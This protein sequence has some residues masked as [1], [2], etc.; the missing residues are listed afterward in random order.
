[1]SEI[2]PYTYKFVFDNDFVIGGFDIEQLWNDIYDVFTD[3]HEMYIERNDKREMTQKEIRK[4]RGGFFEDMEEDTLLIDSQYKNK[5]VYFWNGGMFWSH[6][7]QEHIQDVMGLY[8]Q[9]DYKVTPNN[10]ESIFCDF[11]VE[12]GKDKKSILCR[13]W[14][15]EEV[16]EREEWEKPQIPEILKFLN[17]STPGYEKLM[18]NFEPI[19]EHIKRWIDNKAKFAPTDEILNQR[20]WYIAEKRDKEAKDPYFVDEEEYDEHLIKLIDGVNK[21]QTN[22]EKKESMEKLGAYLFDNIDGFHV[23]EVNII[24]SAEEIDLLVSNESEDIFFEKMGSPIIVE[25]RNRKSRFSAKD[26]RDFVGKIKSLNLNGGAI[27]SRKGISGRIHRDAK[28][29]IRESRRE[30]II[31]IPLDM[32]DIYSMAKGADPIRIMKKKYHDLFKF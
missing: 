27:I 22:Q 18:I 2:L 24:G 31:I 20:N 23:E 29:V 12:K 15:S 16:D 17:S 9:M 32:R 30:G 19:Y 3:H 6:S 11:F 4:L 1:M 26:A 25:C 14:W 28:L 7:H 8:E 10:D 21:S 13:L 5:R